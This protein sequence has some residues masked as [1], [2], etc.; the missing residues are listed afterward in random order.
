ML[1][2]CL[3]IVNGC[4]DR[5][6]EAKDDELAELIINEAG[7]A[8]DDCS[9]AQF[10]R[11]KDGWVCTVSQS[12]KLVFALQTNAVLYELSGQSFFPWL[13]RKVFGSYS[14]L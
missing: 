2:T 9:L 11:A 13:S 4:V 1:L 6:I 7:S 10:A 3:S 8:L 5:A 14:I 12:F